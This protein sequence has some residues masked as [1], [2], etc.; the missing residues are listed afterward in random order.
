LRDARDIADEL[1]AKGVALSLGG[2]R[3]DPTDPV[4][5][6]LFN[7]LGMVAEFERDLISMRTRE[8]MAVARAKGKLKGRQPKLSRTQRALLFELHDSGEHNQSDIAE[9]LNVS[10]ATRLSR[11]AA[12][13]RIV[14]R[15]MRGTYL[16]TPRERDPSST[17]PFAGRVRMWDACGFRSRLILRAETIA[18]RDV[19][20]PSETAGDQFAVTW[21]IRR[22]ADMWISERL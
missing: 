7:V 16:L 22:A 11:A 8:G 18:P 4:G 6:L 21:T 10:R 15:L 1:T 5:R 12:S 9:L 3:Y 19:T 2:S 13:S 17:D 20:M 14:P